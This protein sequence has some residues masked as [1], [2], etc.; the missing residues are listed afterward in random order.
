MTKTTTG[1]E[2]DA[3]ACPKSLALRCRII[4]ALLEIR[5]DDADTMLDELR[6]PEQDRQRGLAGPRRRRSGQ[7]ETRGAGR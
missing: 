6:D 4:E 7:E 2:A 3:A 5:I 1:T